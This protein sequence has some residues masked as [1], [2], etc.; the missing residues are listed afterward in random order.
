MQGLQANPTGKWHL[1]TLTR[2]IPNLV[3]YLQNLILLTYLATWSPMQSV[4]F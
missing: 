3:D 2:F 1:D 4:S